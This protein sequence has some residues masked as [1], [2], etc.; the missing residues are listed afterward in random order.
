MIRALAFT[1]LIACVALPASAREP[2][3]KHVG[4]WSVH[5]DT[6]G[7]T[8]GCFILTT[9]TDGSI[10]RVSVMPD[11]SSLLLMVGNME[12]ASIEAGKDYPIDVRFDDA[13]WWTATATGF[14]LSGV[15]LLFV[16][17]RRDEFFEEFMRK[18]EMRVRYEGRE[19]VRLGLK[20]SFAA[21]QELGRCQTAVTVSSGE[22][23]TPKA[24]TRN[25]GPFSRSGSGMSDPFR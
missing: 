22:S 5:V 23:T 1:I 9:Y 7:Q 17:S 24:G 14:R 25:D 18:H 12:W 20:G 10:L 4:N 21:L 16:E 11:R 13:P 19:I 6:S 2:L 15:P 3:W 8:Y